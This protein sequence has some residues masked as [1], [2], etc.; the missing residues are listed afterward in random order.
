MSIVVD[1]LT[2]IYG[3]Q[4]AIDGVS[5]SINSGEI[6]GFLGPNGAGKSTTMK[7]LTGF[8]SPNSGSAKVA[9]LEVSENP[10]I[11]K[12]KI[13]YLP[14][15]NPLYPEMY[16]KEYLHFSAES[17][18]LKNV[19]PRVKKV[20]ETT[21][22]LLEQNKKIGQLSKGYK[23]R[24]GLAQAL[25]NNPEVLILDEPTSGLDPNQMTDIRK[26]IKQLGQDKTILLSSHIMQEVEAMCDRVI[27]IN[28]GKIVADDLV[29][30]MKSEMSANHRIT[31]VSFRD[32]I[33]KEK[34]ESKKDII[35]LKELGPGTYEL[36]TDE[37]VDLAQILFD[38][39][40]QSNTIIL[41]QREIEKS[42]ESV[43][44]HLTKNV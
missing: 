1:N 36:V 38:F 7:I 22:L 39:A 30:N 2:K 18:G 8:L 26:L 41:E 28:K 10:L 13:G 43:F 31:K 5:F 3:T 4:K 27:I 20:I 23:Q 32:D 21:G 40:I 34:L 12:G 25:L 37:S 24:V 6:V 16:V 42:L 11:T 33:D 35:S 44:Q 19:K 14:E 15:L 9:G 29:E 17:Y